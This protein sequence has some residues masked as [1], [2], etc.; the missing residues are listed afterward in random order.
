M[1]GITC[2]SEICHNRPG[3]GGI[4]F[5]LR[6]VKINTSASCSKRYTNAD[7]SGLVSRTRRASLSNPAT[8][9][10]LQDETTSVRLEVR[11][12]STAA[13]IFAAVSGCSAPGPPPMAA[14][15]RRYT[16]R[17][18]AHSGLDTEH[19]SAESS[20]ISSI[21]PSKSDQ[22][23]S[24]CGVIPIRARPLSSAPS[25]RL[26]SSPS[27]PAWVSSA[28]PSGAEALIR[29]TAPPT[30]SGATRAAS[31][32]VASHASARV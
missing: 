32:S 27:S 11:R 21:G 15:P 28:S 6:R 13:S 12:R 31:I 30:P 2:C 7:A 17:Y 8:T 5:A 4:L 25:G 10:T 16:W 19:R 3:L 29:S 23:L 26:C 24:S 18:C 20:Q 14:L 1:N 9:P 22:S